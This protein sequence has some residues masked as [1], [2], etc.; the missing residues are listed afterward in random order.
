MR[1]L[2]VVAGQAGL[3]VAG[4]A[5]LACRLGELDGLLD[6]AVDFSKLTH[7]GESGGQD[8]GMR[9]RDLAITA[10][11]TISVATIQFE[12]DETDSEPT[13]VRIF[14]ELTPD[15]AAFSSTPG[16]IT[17]RPLTTVSVVW[18]N[19]LPWPTADD[20]GPDQ[21]TPDLTAI[22]QEII[23]QPGW[24]PGNAL[25]IIIYP[26]P[27]T[28]LPDGC[29]PGGERTAESFDGEASA[30]ALL[31]ITVHLVPPSADPP[32]IVGDDS[33]MS[34]LGCGLTN[35]S[36]ET[37]EDVT[38]DGMTATITAGGPAPGVTLTPGSLQV[39][40]DAPLPFY[41]W[42]RLDVDVT[43]QT[44]GLS[45][46][47]TVFMAHT[48]LDVNGDGRTNITD[49]TAFGAVW[50]AGAANTGPLPPKP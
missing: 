24:R 12:V 16:D 28:N 2:A 34:V 25:V 41:E 48:P 22:V 14:G 33:V 15:P 30:A 38:V 5:E 43:G 37:N 50:R 46:T 26:K 17:S 19:L 18:S 27:C 40:L 45:T 9:F 21:R 11:S 44:S 29:T 23:D 8:I 3:D 39:S 1:L 47:L 42:L 32:A 31:S 20:A 6:Q 4:P 10:G 35:A 13:S 36:F 7:F 49:A